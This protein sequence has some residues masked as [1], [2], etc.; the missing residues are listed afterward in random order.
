MVSEHE[1]ESA[2]ARRAFLTV[3][4]VAHYLSVE[5]DMITKWA[6]SGKLPGARE[7]QSWRFDKQR[8]DEWVANG[9]NS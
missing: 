3:D 6:E 5:K 2:G 9:R 8:V 7:G 4:E 1:R